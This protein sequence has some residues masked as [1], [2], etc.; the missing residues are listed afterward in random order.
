MNKRVAEYMKIETIRKLADL[1]GIMPAVDDQVHGIWD[2][3]VK[4]GQWSDILM[5]MRVKD[6]EQR[7]E[8]QKLLQISC[9]NAPP[10][11][12]DGKMDIQEMR[13]CLVACKFSS[14]GQYYRAILTGTKPAKA[15]LCFVDFGNTESKNL[16]LYN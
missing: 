16:F 3:T 10:I 11:N 4:F 8:M 14:D 12:V 6:I 15:R 1:K 7:K 9:T 13:G 5:V 2:A